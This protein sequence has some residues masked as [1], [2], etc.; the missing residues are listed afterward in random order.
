MTICPRLW[1]FEVSAC[2]LRHHLADIRGGVGSTYV[3]TVDVFMPLPKP[4]IQRP[5]MSCGRPNDAA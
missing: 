3:G 5:T 4:V 1:D 2:Q